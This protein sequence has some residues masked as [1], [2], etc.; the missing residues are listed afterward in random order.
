MQFPE[1]ER[2]D[3]YKRCKNL[4]VVISGLRDKGLTAEELKDY[5]PL[6]IQA[7]KDNNFPATE[8]FIDAVYQQI[9]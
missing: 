7:C 8:E 3:E 5:L 4:T 6:V 2:E 9:V 1:N